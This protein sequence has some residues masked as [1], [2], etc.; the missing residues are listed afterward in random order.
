MQKAILTALITLLI[1]RL[2]SEML[3]ITRRHYRNLLDFASFVDGFVESERFESQR[4]LGWGLSQSTWLG[5]KINGSMT[6]NKLVSYHSKSGSHRESRGL[7]F[8]DR[9]IPTDTHMRVARRQYMSS[10]APHEE[11]I[12]DLTLPLAVTHS[13]CPAGM[14]GRQDSEGASGID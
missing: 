12:C 9:S 6:H 7:Q 5:Q 4:R 14:S 3:V 10:V 2:I 13:A 8:E 11:V 1:G